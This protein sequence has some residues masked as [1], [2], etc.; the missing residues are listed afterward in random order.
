MLV[1]Q[2]LEKLR[3]LAPQRRATDQQ[4]VIELLE[5]QYLDAASIER[6]VHLSLELVSGKPTRRR[7]WFAKLVQYGPCNGFH[8]ALC[9]SRNAAAR[10]TSLHALDIRQEFTDHHVQSRGFARPGWSGE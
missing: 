9:L 6:G 5:N 7:Q 2:V 10:D 1:P 4:C 3:E 8:V